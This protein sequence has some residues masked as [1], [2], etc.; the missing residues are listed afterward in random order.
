M[1]SIVCFEIDNSVD[2]IPN[3][4]IHKGKCAWPKK[5]GNVRS[6]IEKRVDPTD[7]PDAFSYYN[8]RIIYQDIGKYLI[9]YNLII[10]L[11]DFHE[12]FL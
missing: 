2:F 1:W 4:W 8:A 5:R 11:I 7:K 6:Y 10:L 9:I 3:F 12:C